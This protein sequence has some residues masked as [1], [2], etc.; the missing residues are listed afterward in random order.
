MASVAP[1]AAISW[2]LGNSDINNAS[3]MEEQADGVVSV[4]SSVYILTALYYG[5]NLTCS[6]DHPSL[7]APEERTISILAQSMLF[8]F[9]ETSTS[10]WHTQLLTPSLSPLVFFFRNPSA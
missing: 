5:Q 4:R 2:L 10:W 1:A 3:E 8:L 7:E 6:V 9:F